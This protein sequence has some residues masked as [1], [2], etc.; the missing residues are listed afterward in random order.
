MKLDGL[1]DRSKVVSL[2]LLGVSGLFAVIVVV[3][4]VGFFVT[5][6]QAERIISKAVDHIGITPDKAAKV[7]E[8]S[9]KTA[10]ELKKSNPFAPPPPKPQNPIREVEIL[11]DSAFIGGKWYKVGDKVA[12][13]KILAIE[14]T[15][16]KY[17]W[18]DKEFTLS[19][20]GKGSSKE[21]PKA[22]D[23]REVRGSSEPSEAGVKIVNRQGTRQLGSKRS[24]RGLSRKEREKRRA[25]LRKL[26]TEAKRHRN[27]RRSVV[28][29]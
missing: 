12:D 1:K 15:C 14:P 24:I 5:T 25:R 19:P 17:R 8:K 21:T 13:A 29:D 10:D 4:V 2:A 7:F 23:K 11:G 16:I 3:D 20:W 18:Q 28:S 27:S 9:K 22:E 26:R 6:S